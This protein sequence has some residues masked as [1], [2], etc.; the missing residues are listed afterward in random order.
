M[1]RLEGEVPESWRSSV[2]WSYGNYLIIET[3]L[4]VDS[5]R[6]N[7]WSTWNTKDLKLSQLYIFSKQ[8]GK[9]QKEESLAVLNSDSARS[10]CLKDFWIGRPF[11]GKMSR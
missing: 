9:P 10:K 5:S 4:V 3:R 7:C 8:S 11:F 2:K 6:S 1:D